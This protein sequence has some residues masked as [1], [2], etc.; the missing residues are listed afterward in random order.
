MAIGFS[1][2]RSHR[3]CRPGRRGFRE[4]AGADGCWGPGRAGRRARLCPAGRRTEHGDLRRQPGTGERLALR[5]I[6]ASLAGRSPPDGRLCGLGASAIERNRA[7]R[8]G[9]PRIAAFAALGGDP[10]AVLLSMLF[11]APVFLQQVQ[12]HSATITGLALLPQGVVMGFA[13][14]LGNVIVGSGRTGPAGVYSVV[15]A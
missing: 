9:Q 8:S 6:S 7:A 15:V 5:A 10:A 14:A 2:Q 13:S 4:S 3:A 11:L 12:L 1:Y